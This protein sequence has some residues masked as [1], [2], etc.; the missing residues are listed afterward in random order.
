MARVDLLS[1][2]IHNLGNTAVR[3][4]DVASCLA[5]ADPPVPFGSVLVHFVIF[6]TGQDQLH[7]LVDAALYGCSTG[8]SHGSLVYVLL[9]R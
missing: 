1:V 2:A 7:D 3:S 4:G 9:A 6:R 5:F 8:L